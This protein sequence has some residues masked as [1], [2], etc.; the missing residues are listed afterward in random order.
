MALFYSEKLRERQMW[1]FKAILLFVMVEEC[2]IWDMLTKSGSN[3]GYKPALIFEYR[4]N[5][6]Q[7]Q[8]VNP[9]PRWSFL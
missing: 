3:T 8:T 2:Q 6:G 1:I 4:R 7:S 9:E 5:L